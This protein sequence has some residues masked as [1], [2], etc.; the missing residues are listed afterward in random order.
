MSVDDIAAQ[1]LDGCRVAMAVTRPVIERAPR[2]LE[3]VGAPTALVESVETSAVSL[4][5]A[6]GVPCFTRAVSRGEIK[7][8]DRTCPAIHAG[9]IA[10]QNGAPFSMMRGLIGSDVL[11]NR[12]DWRVIQAPFS[13]YVDPVV[14]IPPLAPDVSIYWVFVAREMGVEAASAETAEGFAELLWAA[15]CTPGPFLIE[16]VI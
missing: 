11:A 15:V 8:L 5:E 7:V 2:C 10:S 1:V 14:A 3:V 6:G 16:A 13:D 12:N 9:L 4:G